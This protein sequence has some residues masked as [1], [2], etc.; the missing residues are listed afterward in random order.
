MVKA[1]RAKRLTYQTSTFSEQG[2]FLITSGAIHATVPAKVI[3]ALLSLN[4]LHVP[5]SEILRMSSKPTRTLS[6]AKGTKTSTL[7]ESGAFNWLLLKLL[8]A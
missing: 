8:K 1:Q 4:S 2:S 5:K 6:K 3:L 7:V